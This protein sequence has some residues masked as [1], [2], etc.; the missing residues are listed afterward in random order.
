MT[1]V[2]FLAIGTRGDVEP[3][4]V[5]A[6]ALAGRG[7]T[8]QVVGVAEYAGVARRAGVTYH[9]LGTASLDGFRY[10]V[11][12]R[13]ATMTPLAQPVVLR[14]WLAGLAVPVADV[15]PGIVPRGSLV[16]TGIP[17][18][19]V[20]LTLTDALDCRMATVVHTAALPTAQASSH[21]EGRWFWRSQRP[22]RAFANWYWQQM[23]GL[24]ITTSKVLRSRLGLRTIRPAKLVDA[25][26]AWPIL[27][28]ADPVLVPPAPDWP[29]SCRQTAAVLAGIPAGWQPPEHLASFLAGDGPMAYVGLGSLNDSGGSH[30]QELVVEAARLAGVRVVT[31][32]LAG[33]R[34]SIGGDGSCRIADTPHQWLFPRVGAVVHLGGAGTTQAA[35]RAGVP[36]LALPGMFDQHYHA[37]RLHQLGVGPRPLPLARVTV[38]RLASLLR[39][40]VHGGYAPRAAQVG[41]QASERD[42]V[43]L[44]ASALADLA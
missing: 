43:E 7:V 2:T 19:D 25:A 42:G 14:Q 32:A 9:S 39:E 21:L 30:W 35:L 5:L 17:G 29:A 23:S 38:T 28:A 36:S 3:M 18:R 1:S 31:P 40:L 26:D 15:L 11:A 20:A 12:G 8:T 41:A 6:A 34:P 16:V 13:L 33:Q 44:T 37:R 27:L 22:D 24:S 10:S 4:V